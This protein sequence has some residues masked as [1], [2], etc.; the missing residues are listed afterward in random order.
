MSNFGKGAVAGDA[1]VKKLY[2]GVENFRIVSVNPTEAELKELYG[3]NAREETYVSKSELKDANN[4]TVGEADSIRLVFHLNNMDEENPIKARASFYFTKT[5]YMTK[6]GNKQQFIN[7]YGQT[8]WLTKDQISQNLR[9]Y[10]QQGAR[11]TYIFDASGMRPAYKNE[12]KLISMLRNLLNLPGIQKAEKE[13]NKAA[14]ASQLSASDWDAIFR[15]DVSCISN[16][17]KSTE[18]KVGFLLGVKQSDDKRYQD[19]FINSTL[20]QYGKSSEKALGY[21]RTSVQDAQAAGSYPS[22]DFGDPS[23]KLAEF[24]EDAVPTQINKT[25]G[26]GGVPAFQAFQSLDA[27]TQNAFTPSE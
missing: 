7:L 6:D 25:S 18:N 21:L 9:E 26:S 22:T 13:G 8:M 14:S 23:Y 12:D 24:V 17:L 20:R 19:T 16:I 1:G 11:G 27:E 3:E 5:P 15:G 2:T 4:N 10:T